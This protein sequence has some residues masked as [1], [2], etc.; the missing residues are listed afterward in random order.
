MAIHL[1][2]MRNLHSAKLTGYWPFSSLDIPLY[3]SPL[4]YSVLYIYSNSCNPKQQIQ[5][6][7]EEVESLLSQSE[8]MLA[9]NHYAS[10]ELRA[11]AWELRNLHGDVQSRLE[12]RQKTLGDVITFYQNAEQVSIF[13]DPI[14]MFLC[15]NM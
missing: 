4:Q 14:Y 13:G 15:K 11:M 1:W 10:T 2:K 7:A 9:S 6:T 3:N 8:E 5:R 12:L